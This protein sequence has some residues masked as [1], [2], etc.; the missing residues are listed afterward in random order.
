MQ[1]ETDMADASDTWNVHRHGPLE[2]LADNLYRVEGPVPGMALR[3]QMIVIRLADGRLVVHSAIAVDDEVRSELEALGE[4]A[5]LVV[6]CGLH[7][8]DAPAYKER[9]PN[10]EVVCPAAARDKV[11]EVVGVDRTYEEIEPDDTVEFEYLDGLAEAEG[12]LTV[13]SSDGTTLV[14]N[15]ALFNHPHASGFGGLILRL[16]GSTG[17][18]KVTRLARW[19]IVKDKRT[20][21]DHLRRLADTPELVRVIPGHGEV[22]DDDPAGVLRGVADRL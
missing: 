12:V 10:I 17:G 19:F 8:L 21:A 16:I 22:I 13:R 7:R 14:F 2:R 6:P 4:P 11:E 15:D 1:S 20:Y 3:R 9:Y 18:P 5:I